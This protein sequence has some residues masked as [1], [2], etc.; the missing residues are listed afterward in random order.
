LTPVDD[1]AAVPPSLVG[2]IDDEP[3][4]EPA[5]SEEFRASGWRF[6]RGDADRSG[7]RAVF[8]DRA[9]HLSIEGATVVVR[10]DDDAGDQQIDEVLRRHHLAVR[11]PMRFVPKGFQVVFEGRPAKGQLMRI[12]EELEKLDCVRYADPD[13]VEEIGQR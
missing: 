2:E 4:V 12:S 9:G 1:V 11:R 13:F 3:T 10:F 7:L 5:G 6:I 8:R